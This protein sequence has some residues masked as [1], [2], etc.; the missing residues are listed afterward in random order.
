[1]GSVS[2]TIAC[3]FALFTD[4]PEIQDLMLNCAALGFI[5]SVDTSMVGWLGL[6]K[7]T[8]HTLKHSKLNLA[9]ITDA[10]PGSAEQAKLFKMLRSPDRFQARFV[11][12]IALTTMSIM[13][14]LIAPVFTV[15]C[16]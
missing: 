14:M 7:E 6:F 9:K 13:A 16:L 12:A 10:W 3:T 1:M 15:A 8:D 5:P 11:L 4:S 2:L